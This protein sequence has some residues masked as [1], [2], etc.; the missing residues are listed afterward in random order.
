[1]ATAKVFNLALV[2]AAERLIPRRKV[3]ASR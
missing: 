3:L 2:T 1:V